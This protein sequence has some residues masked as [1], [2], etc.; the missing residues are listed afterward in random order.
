[1]VVCFRV[2]LPFSNSVPTGQMECIAPVELQ[3]ALGATGG[4]ERFECFLALSNA[5]K[6]IK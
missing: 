5:C 1:M 3:P 2:Q 4:K 6:Q